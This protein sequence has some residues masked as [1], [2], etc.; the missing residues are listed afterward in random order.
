MHEVENALLILTKDYEQVK[1]IINDLILENGYQLDQ[2]GRC[3]MTDMYFDY[4]DKILKKH[5]IDLRIRS[6]QGETPKITLKVLKKMTSSHSERVE[7]ERSW[8]LESFDE[9]MKELNS[10]LPGHVLEYPANFNNNDPQNI[11]TS[12]KFLKIQERKTERNII[13]VTNSI[14]NDLEFEFAIDRTFYHLNSSNK[15]YGLMELEIESKK[16]GNYEMLDRLVNELISD[17]KSI[18]I[19]W[20]HSKLATGLAMETLISSRELKAA[21]DFDNDGLLILSGAKKIESFIKDEPR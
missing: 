6:I 12:V 2:K 3:T 8:S 10:H 15:D 11:L 20:P 4:K 7:I 9:I 1:K 14:T 13:N 5:K 17:H 16:K 18:F 21:E 19:P